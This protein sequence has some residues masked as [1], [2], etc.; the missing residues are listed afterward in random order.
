M[1]DPESPDAS[2]PAQRSS[3]RGT[4]MTSGKLEDC[5]Q[6]LELSVAVKDD[7]GNDE[8]EADEEEEDSDDVDSGRKVVKVDMDEEEGEA[9]KSEMQ[10]RR[11]VAEMR[12]TPEGAPTRTQTVQTGRMNRV[13]TLRV[14]WRSHTLAPSV[15]RPSSPWGA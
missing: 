9:V 3:L 8:E 1:S 13:R 4:E 5:S 2:D 11:E 14:Q 6:T 15:A 12:P 10:R 7:D